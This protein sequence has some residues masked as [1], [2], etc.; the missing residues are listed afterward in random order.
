ME[1]KLN[2]LRE[3][4]R[5]NKKEIKLS[6]IFFQALY[7]KVLLVQPLITKFFGYFDKL[8]REKF[9]VCLGMAWA[10]WATRN[11]VVM[12]GEHLNTRC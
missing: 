2:S 11:C 8:E 6:D 4:A 12:K 9:E 7:V 1:A 3:Q 5:R 10:L